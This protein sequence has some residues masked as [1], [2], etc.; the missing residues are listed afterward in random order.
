[1]QTRNRKL[2]WL[3]LGGMCAVIAAAVTWGMW[4]E[5]QTQKL[6]RDLI[7]AINI[8]DVGATQSLLGRGAN[9]NISTASQHDATLW[10]LL[11]KRIF[12]VTPLH[13]G[14]PALILAVTKLQS[15]DDDKIGSERGLAVVKALL[16]YGAYVDSEDE[17]GRNVIHTAMK[18]PDAVPILR[19]ALQY[20]LPIRPSHGVQQALL[21]DRK[22][23]IDGLTPLM[24]AS[25]WGGPEE[26]TLLLEA[27]ANVDLQSN[28][29]K[30]AVML[31]V[32]KARPENIAC[33]LAHHAN[34]QLTDRHGNTALSMALSSE[35]SNAVTP[36]NHEAGDDFWPKI[37]LM[38]KRAG[39][40]THREGIL[41]SN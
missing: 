23:P 33:L 5:L 3:L 40:K 37:V 19:L 10:S 27:G 38:L 1:M 26:I 25:L 17:E 16:E 22:E 31:A 20:R 28:D 36:F 13:H 6:D 32:E 34:L 15:T 29:G 4:R 24:V 39:I 7:A 18:S 11:L 14:T 2:S 30:T 21:L 12:R 9:P 41:H 35:S 8:S